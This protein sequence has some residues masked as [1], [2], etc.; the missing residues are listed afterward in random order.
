[1]TLGSSCFLATSPSTSVTA[2]SQEGHQS[3]CRRPRRPGWP[4][5]RRG[6]RRRNSRR[7]SFCPGP[8]QGLHQLTK[9]VV[10]ANQK[11]SHR[12]LLLAPWV[13]PALQLRKGVRYRQ[14]LQGRPAKDR[15]ELVQAAIVKEVLRLKVL[16]DAAGWS[17]QLAPNPCRGH[18]SC[19]SPSRSW[20]TTCMPSQRCHR[21]VG[22]RPR[23]GH[24]TENCLTT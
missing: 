20:H 11:L 7:L 23:L 18:L 9:H 10:L 17:L 19:Q 13:G 24:Q 14:G 22:S 8:L 2:K 4:W 21:S 15:E 6:G 16:H 5:C 3:P 12:L 1:M